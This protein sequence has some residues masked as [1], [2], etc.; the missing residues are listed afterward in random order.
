MTVKKEVKVMADAS[1]DGQSRQAGWGCVIT[2]GETVR[3]I[4][5]LIHQCKDCGQAELI[6]AAVG[7][8]LALET[9]E[10]KPG[11]TLIVQSDNCYALR[12]LV[13]GKTGEERGADREIAAE[14]RRRIVERGVLLK[15]EHVPGHSGRSTRDQASNA[16]ADSSARACLALST[17]VA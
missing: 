3:S 15:T 2:F 7:A 9:A 6:A 12:A 10:M 4:S 8:K 1:F 16:W 14:V 5:G 11:D 17:L 13:G